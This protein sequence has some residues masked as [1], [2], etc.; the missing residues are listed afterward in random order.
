MFERH[1]HIDL[2][3]TLIKPS[4]DREIEEERL[5]VAGMV[6]IFTSERDKFLK[7]LRVKDEKIG[8]LEAENE[9]KVD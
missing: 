3:Q 7:K 4:E 1:A 9:N 6:K 2:S 5:K 8:L